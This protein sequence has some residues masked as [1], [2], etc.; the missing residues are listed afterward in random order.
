MKRRTHA[1]LVNLLKKELKLLQ[2]NKPVG[3]FEKAYDLIR[4]IEM[5]YNQD[6]EAGSS[7]ADTTYQNLHK[8]NNETDKNLLAIVFDT[9]P[10]AV[11]WKDAD[12]R[13]KYVNQKFL[14]VVGY[15]YLSD[16]EGKTDFELK[17]LKDESEHFRVS[18]L[19]IAE[20]QKPLLG[21]KEKLTT[22]EGKTIWLKSHK[23][24]IITENGKFE[25]IIGVIEDISE[26]QSTRIALRHSEARLKSYFNNVTDG[27]F[28]LDEGFTIQN[29]NPATFDITGLTPE[30]LKD[31][32]I[33]DLFTND[34]SLM[35]VKANCFGMDIEPVSGECSMIVNDR[36]L[37]Y[38]KID[39][40]KIEIDHYICILK[41]V[42][43]LTRAIKKAQ[44]SNK[45]KTAFL[46]NISHEIRTPLNAIIGFSNILIRNM[47]ESEEDA[48]RYKK[49]IFANS[50]YL[51]GL[52]NSV[53]DLS[54]IEAGQTNLNP[55]EII[56]V[57]F[58]HNEVLPIIE[59]ERNRLEKSDIQIHIDTG[60]LYE[61]LSM[62]VDANR[63][64][65]IIVNLMHNALK[66][67]ME[68]SVSLIVKQ[69]NDYLK[70]E[71]V[72]SGIGI[73][74]DQLNRIFHR[75]YKIINSQQVSMGSGLGL[76]IVKKL[77]NLMNGDI[78]VS[79]VEGKGST[80]TFVLPIVGD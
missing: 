13:F 19:K 72:D 50:E 24:P 33:F 48:I 71:V 52:V 47:Y 21:I 41:D 45:L 57:P 20:S 3:D 16:V 63:L 1:E 9:I 39:V 27:I 58:L 76:A 46:Q 66:F 55:E 70:F 8:N 56:L 65:Q 31:K 54:K 37:K 12:F 62:Y 15:K 40:V 38:L 29:V 77:L 68:G 26:R 61:N 32:R 44:E 35:K 4:E 2:S 53:I 23:A 17:W 43:E 59:S 73:N 78:S 30:E 11:F 80:F 18:D 51:L 69:Q 49:I 25:G 22:A 14:E 36:E 79:S 5:A 7:N 60:K 28:V 10:G 74:K 34:E 42:S 75:F 64:K 67:T 6:S